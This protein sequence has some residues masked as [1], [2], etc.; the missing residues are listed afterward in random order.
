MKS[1]INSI[2][3]DLQNKI[4]QMKDGYVKEIKDIIALQES[5]TNANESEND[6]INIILTVINHQNEINKYENEN[7]K[8]HTN[9]IDI[10]LQKHISNKI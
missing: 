8:S 10:E 2:N 4:F 7:V 5:S 3:I 9:S 6:D 1:H